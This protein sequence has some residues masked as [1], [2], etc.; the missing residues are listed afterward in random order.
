MVTRCG[1][2]KVEFEEPD[3][4]VVTLVGTLS[5]DEGLALVEARNA[6]TEGKSYFMVLCHLR[7]FSGISIAGNRALAEQPDTRPQA[8]VFVGASFRSRVIAEM[9]VRAASIFAK[10]KWWFHF[11]HTESEARAWLD[12]IRPKLIARAAG[13]R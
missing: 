6:H 3:L 4:L 2:H 7:D 11:A 12:E 13:E 10:Q 1:E 5:R 9:V 8:I